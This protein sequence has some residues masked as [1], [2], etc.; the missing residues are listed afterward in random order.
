ML[1][2]DHGVCAICGLDTCRLLAELLYHV[3]IH[4]SPKWAATPEVALKKAIWLTEH[5]K[6]FDTLLSISDRTSALAKNIESSFFD[7]NG[8]NPITIV[9][10]RHPA[11]RLWEADHI[12][13]VYLGGGLCGLDGYR[14]LCL[15]CH[16]T[17][18]AEQAKHRSLERA[19][20]KNLI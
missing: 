20:K 15:W 7:Q 8:L 13:P 16:R 5:A 9:A 4:V 6:R 10:R 3:A 2:R 1:Q 12:I 18:T 17:H 11:K 19:R 14:T